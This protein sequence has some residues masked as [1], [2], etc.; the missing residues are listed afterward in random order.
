MAAIPPTGGLYATL[1]VGRHATSFAEIYATFVQQAPFPNEREL[2]FD[3]L[4]LYARV[5]AQEFTKPALWINGGFVTHKPWAAPNDTDVV[6]YTPDGVFEHALETE[7]F[8]IL[9]LAQRR[10]PD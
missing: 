5:L 4:L 6:L 1:P 7:D 10:R 8:L 2:I 3:A 9:D